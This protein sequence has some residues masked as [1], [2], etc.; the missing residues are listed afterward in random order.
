MI[1][2]GRGWWEGRAFLIAFCLAASIP[3]WFSSIAPLGDYPS[4]MA[5]YRV[6]MDHAQ[7]PFLARD[8]DVHW[9]LI[10]NLGIDLL[11]LPL[12]K[13]F[14]LE[15]A[16]WAIAAAI[17]VLTIWG[18]ARIARVIHGRVPGSALLAA[19]FA[20]GFPYQYGF[21]NFSLGMALAFHAFATWA[22]L[23]RRIGWAGGVGFA[24]AAGLIWL[25]HAFAWGVLCV[26]CGGYELALS[27]RRDR[28]RNGVDHWAGAAFA[29]A[30]RCWPLL[31][32]LTLM[33]FWRAGAPE[34][35][36]DNWFNWADKGAWILQALRDES[37]ALD[38]ASVV[39][40]LAVLCWGLRGQALRYTRALAVPA[41]ILA[42]LFV[43]LPGRLIGSSFADMRMAPIALA[44]AALALTARVPAGRA[45]QLVAVLAVLL[46]ASR[47]AVGAVGFSQYDRRY[48]SMLRALDYV[49]RGAHVAA[50]VR[51]ACPGVWRRDRRDHLPSIAVVRR[52]AFVNTHWDE[53]AQ[54][55]RPRGGAGTPYNSDP[56]QFVDGDC[57]VYDDSLAGLDESVLAV[58]H[59]R[60]QRVWII[61]FDPGGLVY[62]GLKRLYAD[63]SSALFAVEPIAG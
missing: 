24:V 50:F 51:G 61:G 57:G 43:C 63:D 35:A 2:P 28:A 62:P 3:L 7:S 56:S 21:V 11:I 39:V 60:F 34:V 53:G 36:T 23:R 12:G 6:L 14:G 42:V 41:L 31:P 46:F 4:H 40:V 8:W 18:Y 9:R 1:E 33:L 15:Q 5:R 37:K 25:C 45:E 22:W 27:L 38:I 20:M 59:D 54:P 17:P 49:P 26:L 47:I 30:A 48:A 10:G 16:A 32:P 58:P 52:E 19:P 55:A 44:V 29:A 13:L